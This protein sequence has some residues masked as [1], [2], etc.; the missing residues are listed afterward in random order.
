LNRADGHGGFIQHKIIGTGP[1]PQL[2][3][4]HQSRLDGILMHIVQTLSKLV[5]V[6]SKT[7][8]KLV[9][10]KRAAGVAEPVFGGIRVLPAAEGHNQ[11]AVVGEVLEG[12]P[13][14]AYRYGVQTTSHASLA[15]AEYQEGSA[16]AAP[17]AA[18]SAR[19]GCPVPVV[20]KCPATL[21]RAGAFFPEADFKPWLAP[22]QDMA[23]GSLPKTPFSQAW[24]TT[25]CGRRRKQP[26]FQLSKR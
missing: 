22:P 10:P 7:V 11:A 3:A 4:L 25:G 24:R 2:G 23:Y 19:W 20:L 18:T 26:S 8:P 1:A 15:T 12:P 16:P 13:R 17:S 14:G 6:A 21:E 9:L 5:C